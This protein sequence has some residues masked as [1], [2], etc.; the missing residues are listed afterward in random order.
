MT[1][2]KQICDKSYIIMMYR[3]RS[4][5]MNTQEAI[6]RRIIEIVGIHKKT[7]CEISLAGGITPA[8]I[9]SIMSGKSKKALVISIKKFCEGCGMTLSEFFA[10]EY[11]NQIEFD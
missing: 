5:L 10:P 7:I 3:K 8:T 9:Y 2:R 6:R 11:F 1:R 4:S